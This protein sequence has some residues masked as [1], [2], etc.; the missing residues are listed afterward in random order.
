[1]AQSR[2]SEN[3]QGEINYVNILCMMGG[4]FLTLRVTNMEREKIIMKP[5]LLDYNRR[6]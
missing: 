4:K 3:E 1:M 2:V 6:Y 5:I